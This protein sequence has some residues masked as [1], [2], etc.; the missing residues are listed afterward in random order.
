MPDG[1]GRLPKSR[2]T[3][4][5]ARGRQE[6]EGQA[7][8][9]GACWVAS[10]HGPASRGGSLATEVLRKG[11]RTRRSACCGTYT[12]VCRTLGCLSTAPRAAALP[13]GWG[14]LV[15][16]PPPPGPHPR[17]GKQVQSAL[18]CCGRAHGTAGNVK[19][20]R[21]NRRVL[22]GEAGTQHCQAVP[23]QS[24]TPPWTP[25]CLLSC[26]VTIVTASRSP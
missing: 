13:A 4:V 2:H 5:S 12:A 19:D 10:H 8:Q 1:L 11:R 17:G 7:G 22:C 20:R 18:Q 16:P 21:V 26:H 23:P 24:C 6:G 3:R 15:H 9:Q 25:V 14:R